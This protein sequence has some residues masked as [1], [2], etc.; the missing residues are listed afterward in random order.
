MA[1]HVEFSFDMP[2]ASLVID[3]VREFFA[4]GEAERAI[5]AYLPAQRIRV[6]QHFDAAERRF[7][8]ARSLAADLP[9][10]VLLREGVTQYLAAA[11]LARDPDAD[12]AALDLA[13][14]L[15]PI[16]LDPARPDAEATDDARVRAIVSAAD[17]LYF[18][19]LAPADLER[20]RA[21]LERAG[22]LLRRRIEAR[23]LTGVKWTRWGRVGALALA[24]ICALFG[25]VRVALEPTDIAKGKPVSYTSLVGNLADGRG[26]V[27]GVI[28]TGYGIHTLTEESPHVV[29]DLLAPYRI[30]GI[31]VHNRADG[32][33]DECLPLLV[34]LSTDGRTYSELGKRETHFDADPPWDVDGHMEPARYVRLRV[35][36]RGYI[37]LS[38]VEVFGK[39]K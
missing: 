31:R 14:H 19:R 39:K 38:E 24:G 12:P 8:A 30:T 10:A 18:D 35:P 9:A 29:I 36:R 21:A 34:E 26:L 28:G 32:W 22:S 11:A 33:Y 27:D 37:A 1:S 17:P 25:V 5:R 4:L 23:S 7:L 6:R 2:L 13:A 3:P 16:P 15:P 20:D